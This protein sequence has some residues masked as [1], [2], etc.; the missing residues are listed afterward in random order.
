MGVVLFG[1]EAAATKV[2]M[3]LAI[4]ADLIDGADLA[5]LQHNEQTTL[6]S[7]PA[8]EKRF[9]A[10]SSSLGSSS[11]LNSPV[12]SPSFHRHSLGEKGGPS[13]APE[14]LKSLPNGVATNAPAMTANAPAEVRPGGITVAT[15]QA[16]GVTRAKRRA[17]QFGTRVPMTGDTLQ[18]SLQMHC[19]VSG[20]GYAIY[21]TRSGDHVR[22]N[23]ERHATNATHACAA[24]PES[25]TR[26]PHARAHACESLHAKS[27]T[28]PP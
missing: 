2:G 20:A 13:G 8:A 19:E 15:G 27:P 9:A 14:A 16:R 3:G 22:E 1:S 17:E 10:R 4:N 24:H 12:T 25:T 5:S 6:H 11:E 28:A 23:A 18:A 26:W 21:W 7:S